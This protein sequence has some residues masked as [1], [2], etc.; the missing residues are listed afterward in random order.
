MN[1]HKQKKIK[2]REELIMANKEKEVI[3]RVEGEIVE[4]NEVKTPEQPQPNKKE[5]KEKAKLEKAKADLEYKRELLE[6]LEN[7]EITKSQYRKELALYQGQKIGKKVLIVA[8]VT[9]GV[10]AIGS[11]L[12]KS[13]TTEAPEE[14]EVSSDELSETN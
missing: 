9:T 1:D 12:M 13:S 11:K 6:K 10:V 5:L 3:E 14:D 4:K 7:G 8:G 2:E